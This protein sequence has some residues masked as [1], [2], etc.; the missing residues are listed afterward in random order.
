MYAR[1]ANS[2]GDQRDPSGG[3]RAVGTGVPIA[4]EGWVWICPGC[5]AREV[6]IQPELRE[7][8][9]D[10][11]TPI[12]PVCRIRMIRVPVSSDDRPVSTT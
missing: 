8:A 1:K 12:C 6:D 2:E 7:V 5:G 10:G 3:P 11:T 9:E 4:W